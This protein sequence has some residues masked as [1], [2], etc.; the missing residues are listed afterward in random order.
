[1]NKTFRYEYVTINVDGSYNPETQIGGYAFWI[2]GPQGQLKQCG[3]FANKIPSTGHAPLLC[4]TMA[5]ANAL[6]ALLSLEWKFDK[7][8]INNDCKSGHNAIKT[9]QS[10][11]AETQYCHVLF[12]KLKSLRNHEYKK[13]INDWVEF[14]HIQAHAANMEGK[15]YINEWCD[16]N[17]RNA[18]R[19]AEGKHPMTM[20]DKDLLQP[21]YKKH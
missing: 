9:G 15:G 1:M 5:I 19:K 13:E 8:I 10:E 18:R 7:L 4:E 3:A 14:R 11:F 16:L 12:Q 21:S 2:L 20:K 17:A 6:Y